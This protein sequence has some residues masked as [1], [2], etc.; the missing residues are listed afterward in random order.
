[1]LFLYNDPSMY[2]LPLATGDPNKG[3]VDPD[4]LSKGLIQF[5]RNDKSQ[6]AVYPVYDFLARYVRKLHSDRYIRK[7]LN[8][9]CGQSFLDLIGPSDV[10]YVICLLKNSIGVWSHDP[11]AVEAENDGA[12]VS[13]PKPLYTRGENKKRKFGKTTWSQEGMDFYN[14]TLTNWKKMFDRKL[15]FFA[16][17]SGGWDAWLAD[18]ACLLNPNGWTRKDLHSLLATRTGS[19]MAGDIEKDEEKIVADEEYGYNS[20]D[21]GGPLIGFGKTGVGEGGNNMGYETESPNT[22]MIIRTDNDNNKSRHG[23]INDKE[24]GNED[25]DHDDR[26]DDD[27]NDD[28]DDGGGKL[29][30][31]EMA[32]KARESS[33]SSDDEI[34]DIE[35][36]RKRRNK[37]DKSPPAKTTAKKQRVSKRSGK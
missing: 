10:A 6:H 27:D 28:D 16:I 11:S 9:N 8:A 3:T 32:D 5:I 22:H 30:A 2:T 17:L 36:L 37:K 29:P 24:E 7:T 21:E 31:T 15:S 23:S 25:N 4:K 33:A 35:L 18:E 1:M 14:T 13:V 12:E 19:D 20:D 26:M 34:L